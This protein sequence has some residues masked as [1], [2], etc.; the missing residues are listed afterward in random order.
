MIYVKTYEKFENLIKY[1]KLMRNYFDY[2]GVSEVKI[3][4]PLEYKGRYYTNIYYDKK[5]KNLTVKDHFKGIPFDPFVVGTM[6]VIKLYKYLKTITP[7]IVEYEKMR[8]N[9]DKYNI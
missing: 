2:T 7:E 4:P 1:S 8:K 9:T 3:F 5:T 6:L